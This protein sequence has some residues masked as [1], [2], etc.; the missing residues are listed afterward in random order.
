MKKIKNS[1]ETTTTKKIQVNGAEFQL[2]SGAAIPDRK[3]K[4][5][6]WTELYAAMEIGQ[7]VD[8]KNENESKALYQT[9]RNY[10]GKIVTRK[11]GN[12]IRVWKTA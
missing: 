1:V 7:A 9:A 4:S 5:G 2:I 10:G 3:W 12:L 8:V 6:K 11:V